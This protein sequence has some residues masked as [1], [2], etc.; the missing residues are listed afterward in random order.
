MSN[1]IQYLNTLRPKG[2][3]PHFT[4]AIFKCIFLN[5]NVWIPIKLSWKFVP[6]CPINNIPA[7]I[8]IMAW[9]SPGS[10][11]LSEP[12]VVSLPMHMCI[13]LPQ[14]VKIDVRAYQYHNSL[15]IPIN[16]LQS[17]DQCIYASA[18]WVI[19]RSHNGLLP[20]SDQSI[21]WPNAAILLI[22]PL[23]IHFNEI[24]V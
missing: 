16:S 9:H 8:Q 11:P 19:I 13:T 4:D 21:I 2:N 22:R 7:L 17:G 6:K 10:K 15:M 23:G 1:Y 20:V 12:I 24:W 14:W 3:R 5:E 18:K